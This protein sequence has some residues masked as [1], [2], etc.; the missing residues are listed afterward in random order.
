MSRRGTFWA[1]MAA[2]RRVRSFHARQNHG[3]LHA[4]TDSTDHNEPEA[5]ITPR[6]IDGFYTEAMILAD[7]ARAYFEQQGRVAR[8]RS[9]RPR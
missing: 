9:N 5:R 1:P 7:E 4:M 6:L 3:S 8:P 2:N